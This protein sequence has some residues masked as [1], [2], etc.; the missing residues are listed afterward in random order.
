MNLVS[1]NQN[2]LKFFKIEFF[3]DYIFFICSFKYF[4]LKFNLNSKIQIKV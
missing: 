4:N 3:G 1:E 2:V